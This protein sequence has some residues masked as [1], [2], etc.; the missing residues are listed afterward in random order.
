[1]RTYYVF[2]KIYNM[3]P[4][5]SHVDSRIVELTELLLTPIAMK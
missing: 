3:C 4:G 5:S 2:D 1:M